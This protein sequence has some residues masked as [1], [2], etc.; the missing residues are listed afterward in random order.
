MMLVH[1]AVTEWQPVIICNQSI[2]QA[3]SYKYHWVQVDD[4]VSR[5]TLDEI[6]SIKAESADLFL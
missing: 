4:T 1:K 6:H 5:T 3:S 2:T